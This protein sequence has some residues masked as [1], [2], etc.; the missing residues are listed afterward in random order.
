MARPILMPRVQPRPVRGLHE[1][2]AMEAQNRS[3]RMSGLGALGSPGGHSPG[4]GSEVRLQRVTTPPMELIN[5]EK[6]DIQYVQIPAGEQGTVATLKLMKKLVFSPWGARNP[7]VALIARKIVSHVQSKDYEAEADAIFQYVKR[8]VRYRLDPVA[9]EWLQ[10]PRY[11]LTTQ[12]G[13][14]DDHSMVIASLAL[15]AGHRAAFRTVKGDPQ[16]PDAW[17]HV[18][19]VIGVTKGGETQWYAADTTQQQSKLGWDPPESKLFGMATWV[20]EPD[21]SVEDRQWR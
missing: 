2:L 10:T 5:A 9:L 16:R 13:D 4:I 19:G 12:Q 17:S 1:W 15:A 7:D 18:Y 21:I 14:C 20:L 8:H 11:T 3:G 6:P